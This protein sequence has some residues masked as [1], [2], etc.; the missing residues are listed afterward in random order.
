M[1]SGL[2]LQ[3]VRTSLYLVQYRAALLCLAFAPC[4]AVD[5][6][7]Q[8]TAD[9]APMA[10]TSLGAYSPEDTRHLYEVAVVRLILTRTEAEYGPF[11]LEEARGMTHSRAIQSM[12][13]NSYPN[14]ARSFGYDEFIATNPKIELIPFPVWRGLIGYRVC[15]LNKKIEQAFAK[16]RTREE[17]L[18]FSHGQGEGW[19]DSEILQANG[20]QVTEISNYTS[21]FKMAAAQRYD[22]F[23]RGASEVR[24]EYQK[25]IGKIN[26]LTLDRSKAFYY[27]VPHFLY[28][29]KANTRGIA[30]LKLGIERIIAD[31]SFEALWLLHH[32]NNL[33][34]VKLDQREIITLEN[35]FLEGFDTNYEHLI[36]KPRALHKSA[37]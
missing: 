5:T 35:P 4:L 6:M 26:N 21:L 34:F 25:F 10:F 33:D 9:D 28:I 17:L 7:A 2:T 3:I 22:L 30:R 36:Y 1:S 32:E 8:A 37:R 29:N 23:C 11:T 27:P 18:K 31:G 15:F 16:A 13:D 14:F 24:E 20:F 12:S 19:V